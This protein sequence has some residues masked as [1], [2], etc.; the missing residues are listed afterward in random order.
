MKRLKCCALVMAMTLAALVAGCGGNGG[1]PI[2]TTATP[3]ETAIAT[4]TEVS[5]QPP[6]ATSTAAEATETVAP[7]ASETPTG[8][9]PATPTST[10]TETS[11]IAAAVARD[12]DGVAVHLGETLTVEGVVTVSAGVFANN[13]LKIFIQDGDVAIMVYHQSSA[14]VDAFQAGDRLRATGVIRQEDPTSDS[15]PAK[16]TV[17]VDITSG[18]W[19]VLSAGNPLPAAQL[20]TLADLQANGDAFTGTVVRVTGVRKVDGDWP[21]LGSKSTQVT[22]SDDGG[23]ST[24][25]LRLQRNTIDPATV[26]KVEAIGDG[27]FDLTG[28]VVQDDGTDDGKLLSGYEIW[29]RGA[30]D[31]DAG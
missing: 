16:G 3:T 19:E 26:S 22:V 21:A 15:N 5:T 28:I 31:I 7:A 6:T 25:V 1:G 24:A 4:A 13:K 2:A 17:A 11:S 14:D 29:I 20:V 12:A 8:P 23:A 27:V 10:P 18:S 30:D 9:P